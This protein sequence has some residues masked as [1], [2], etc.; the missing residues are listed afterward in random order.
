MHKVGNVGIKSLSRGLKANL[1]SASLE[2]FILTIEHCCTN[3]LLDLDVLA[4]INRALLDKD[5]KSPS[6]TS[7]ATLVQTAEHSGLEDNASLYC[8]HHQLCVIYKKLENLVLV[9]LVIVNP[10]IHL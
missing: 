2:V 3:S 4:K 10:N 6:L 7:N 5:H 9:R 8:Q 1:A